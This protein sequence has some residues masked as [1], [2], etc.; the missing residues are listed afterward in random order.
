M[1]YKGYHL[2]LS[3]GE[4]ALSLAN[5]PSFCAEWNQLSNADPKFTLIQSHA[6][7]STWYNHYAPAF[8]PIL[9]EARD[10]EDKLIGLLPLAIEKKTGKLTHAGDE[11]A[12][13]HG[14]LALPEIEEYFIPNCLD[15]I[16]SELEVSSWSWRWLP[17]KAVYNWLDSES[18]QE[19]G[20]YFEIEKTEAPV[21]N[22]EDTAKLSKINK[23]K[24]VKR[25]LRQYADRGDLRYE[26]I[27][28]KERTRE[29]MKEFG[30]QSDFKK[31]ALYNY[32]FFEQDPYLEGFMTDLQDYPEFNH[33][34][35]LFLDDYPIAFNHGFVD[36]NELCLAG[37]TSYDPSESK[38]SP[39]KL[40]LIKLAEQGPAEGFKAIDLSPGKDAYKD[41]FATEYRDLVRFKIFFGK[42]AQRK[43]K[44]KE[45]IRHGFL[46]FCKK[47]G[48]EDGRRKVLQTDIKA[49][50][51]LVRQMKFADWSRNIIQLF[52]R[53]EVYYCYKFLGYPSG[54][55]TSEGLDVHF[56]RYKD[57][58]DYQGS[59]PFISRRALLKQS[60]MRFSRGDGL[61]SI[62]EN[63]RLMQYGWM[64]EGKYPLNFFRAT[65]THQ[66]PA[67]SK[68]LYGFYS[69]QEAD[70]L[71]YQQAVILNMLEDCL[72]SGGKNVFVCYHKEQKIP[73]ALHKAWRMEPYFILEQTNFLSFFKIVSKKVH[74]YAESAA[75]EDEVKVRPFY[76]LSKYVKQAAQCK[77]SKI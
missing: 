38:H 74:S 72:E 39:G 46:H 33:F 28:D 60:L 57:L 37:Y 5:S 21:W 35:V 32:R 47:I 71:L 53:K 42:N 17:P 4:I 70:S 20:I 76:E 63:G 1:E 40:H 65:Y 64:R 48:L 75:G 49:I 2:S 26:R 10:G 68:V 23:R 14:W 51:G 61:Y 30:L 22:L 27:T 45:N 29:L 34:S 62:S 69:D 44:M 43:G 6:F 8:E 36:N 41:R 19:K 52:Y 54:L 31:E 25:S 18:F 77:K 73:Q 16:Q 66:F 56:N 50:P 3:R 7:V 24:N 11:M 55:K 12:E 9:I 59:Y 13:Y 67:D 58:Y 15:L